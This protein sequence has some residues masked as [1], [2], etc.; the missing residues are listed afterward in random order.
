M[1]S[2]WL[3]LCLTFSKCGFSKGGFLNGFDF[4]PL[5][6]KVGLDQPF[7]KVEWISKG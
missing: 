2:I 5:F 7:S 1:V 6:P 4:A 3:L